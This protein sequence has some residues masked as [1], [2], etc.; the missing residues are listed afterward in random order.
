MT[1]KIG[2]YKVGGKDIALSAVDGATISGNLDGIG[3]LGTSGLV[4]AGAGVVAT[5]GGV[6]ERKLKYYNIIIS[7]RC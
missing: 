2:K 5:T 3:T 6:T 4:T 7:T 1:K